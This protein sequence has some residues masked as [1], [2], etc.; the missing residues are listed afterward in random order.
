MK[1]R[2]FVGVAT[3]AALLMLGAAGASAETFAVHVVSDRADL[4]SGGDAL[5]SVGLPRGVSPASVRVALNGSDITSQFAKRPD[6]SYEGLVTGL[7]LG[8]NSLTAEAP[9]RSSQVTIV[10]H[11]NGGPVF[12]GPQV[13]PWVCANPAATDSQC[14]APTTYEYKYKNALTGQLESYDPSNPPQSSSIASV[15]TDNGQTV[16]YIVRVETGYQDRDQYRIAVLFQPG[17]PWAAWAPQPQ[18]DHKLLITHGA[19][20]GIERESGSAPSVIDETALSKGFAVMSTALDNAGHNCNIVTEAESLVMAK[21]HLIEQYGTLRYAIGTGC[22]GGSLV[23][24]QVANAYPGIYQ[25]I[26]PQCSFQDAWSNGE[27][28]SDYHQTRKYFEHPEQW[29]LG[30]VWSYDQIAAVEGHPNYVNP[31]IFDTVYWEELA[32]PTK[33]CPGVESSQAY[34]PETNPSGVRCTLA[35][36][37]VNVF[38]PRPEKSWTPVERQL[39]HGFAGRPVGNVGVQY[40][41]HALE[42]GI[43]TPAQF[44][45]LNAK[46]GGADID[47]TQTAQRTKAD[48]PALK[49]AYLSGAVNEANNLVNV[50]IIDLRGP[51][52]GA[53][54]DA[55]RTW[56]MR[57]RL[58]RDE[59]H[60]P[61]NDVIWFG[62]AP[63]IGSP[64]YTT[65]ALLAMDS[66][67]SAV[68]ADNRKVSLAEKVADD[69]PAAVHDKCSNAEV[70]EEVSVPGI[71][72][73]CQLPLAQTRF[74]TPRVVAGESITTDNQE[75]QL[76][77]L[78]QSAYYPVTFTAEQW[79][80][81]QQACPTVVC[82][83]S[84]PG[85]SQQ[86]TVPWRTYQNDGAGGAVV[87]GGKALGPAP[88]RS[89]E[90]WTSASFAGWLE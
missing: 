65:E 29:G 77:P 35:D 15:T 12:S 63:L 69:R 64:T 5:V 30:V 10:N 66:W 85:V 37:M 51:D 11:P 42:E 53:F 80:Q 82:D 16:P 36:Y 39:G 21:E 74:A 32:N 1:K 88:A 46:I 25:G 38:G 24:Q 84:K 55:Y 79:A 68:E 76:K 40:G 34:N 71:G 60:F 89:G 22:S 44:A 58:E 43:I 33:S 83:F 47:L 2:V 31:I 48:E 14:D 52:P 6:G 86:N 75:C 78:M 56:S 13:Q 59:G 70:V 18:F 72:P 50:P 20:C 17:Q 87:Y 26:L 28:I 62:E 67:L 45:D 61:K 8:A 49:Y 41:L 9:G 19:S 23:Q 4:I 81:L 3:I 7:Q 57:A 27:E 73:V 54:H 90:G